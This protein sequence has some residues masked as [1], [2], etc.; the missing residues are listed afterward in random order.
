MAF[1]KF[2][3]LSLDWAGLDEYSRWG[4]VVRLIPVNRFGIDKHDID[5]WNSYMD[6]QMAGSYH[7]W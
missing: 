4:N 7:A 3:N 2:V 1:P 5:G 6:I